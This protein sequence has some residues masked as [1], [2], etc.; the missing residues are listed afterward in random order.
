[1]VPSNKYFKNKGATGFTPGCGA[2]VFT[3]VLI[4]FVTMLINKV[5]EAGKQNIYQETHSLDGTVKK[6]SDTFYIEPQIYKKD[7]LPVFFELAPS[8]GTKVDHTKNQ[9]V[10]ALRFYIMSNRRSGYGME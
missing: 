6:M 4:V 5:N 7:T 8:D 9:W 10:N 1:M 2:F 3:S